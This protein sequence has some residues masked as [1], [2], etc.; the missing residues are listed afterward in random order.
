VLCDVDFVAG[1]VRDRPGEWSSRRWCEWVSQ[2]WSFAIDPK[3]T[4]L[5]TWGLPGVACWSRASGP[6]RTLDDHQVERGKFVRQLLEAAGIPPQPRSRRRAYQWE[7]LATHRP[8]H[9]ARPVLSLQAAVQLATKAAH[10]RVTIVRQLNDQAAVDTCVNP[11]PALRAP[12]SSDPCD[13]CSDATGQWTG[14]R[15]STARRAARSVVVP[16]RWV[17]RHAVTG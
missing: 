1:F 17:P 8:R 15:P 3:A 6:T 9:P 10:H 11:H 2:R 12:G 13:G 7:R 5:N 4:D 14:P 16:V